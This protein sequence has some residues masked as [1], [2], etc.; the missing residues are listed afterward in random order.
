MKG[1]R[2][3]RPTVGITRAAC[4]SP[5]GRKLETPGWLEIDASMASARMLANG[6]HICPAESVNDRR[7][8]ASAVSRVYVPGMPRSRH[9]LG[10]RA[11]GSADAVKHRLLVLANVVIGSNAAVCRLRLVKFVL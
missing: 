4:V 8:C 7:H 5:T 6:V 1:E 2:Y 11:K 10:K 9:W 3:S